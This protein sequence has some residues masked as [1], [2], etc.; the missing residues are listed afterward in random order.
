MIQ[1]PL[2]SYATVYPLVL[3]LFPI[4]SMD[5]LGIANVYWS[6]I[7]T[8]SEWPVDYFICLFFQFILYFVFCFNTFNQHFHTY[9]YMGK[10]KSEKSEDFANSVNE[11]IEH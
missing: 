6:R 4:V 10:Q 7:S 5:S 8:S 3:S 9:N 2:L 11:Y 1:S